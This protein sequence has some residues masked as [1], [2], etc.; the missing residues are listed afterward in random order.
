MHRGADPFGDAPF[1]HRVPVDLDAHKRDFLG[2][3]GLS[4]SISRVSAGQRR[5][6]EATLS[7]A[8]LSLAEIDWFVLPNLGL[9]RLHNAYFQP[10]GIDPARTTWS[11]LKQVG[12]LGPADQFAGLAALVDAGRLEPGQRCMLLGVGAGFS[13]SCA[14]LEMLAFPSWHSVDP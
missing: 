11:W 8:G 10:F 14:V 9:R 5:S 1:S 3:F 6:I 2:D 4:S 13:W 7:E 12:H